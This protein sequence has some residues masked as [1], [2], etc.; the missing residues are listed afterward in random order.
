MEL[1]AKNHEEK[2][3]CPLS[4]V[5]K[6]EIP[7]L[8]KKNKINYSKAI[9]YKTVCSDLSSLSEVK[10]DILVF[11]SPTGIKSLLHNFPDFEQN[12]TKI[13]VFGPTTANAV[14]EAGLRIDIQ[15]PNPKAPSMTMALDQF[16]TDFN[17]NN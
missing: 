12:N 4:D 15:A 7:E 6:A 2:Y 14:K 17:K 11:F 9:L 5:H 13:A 3:I 8:L 16:I 1:I 10:Y